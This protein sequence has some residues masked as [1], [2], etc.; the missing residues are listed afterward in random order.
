MKM[1]EEAL[2]NDC[3]EVEEKP[4]YAGALE[5]NWISPVWRS[6]V[7]NKQGIRTERK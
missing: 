6:S 3:S 4:A 2:A 1:A 7:Y 5:G